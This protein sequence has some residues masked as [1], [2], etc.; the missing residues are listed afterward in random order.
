LEE[1]RTV[2]GHRIDPDRYRSYMVRLWREAS[3]APWRCHVQCVGRDQARCF[4]GLAELFEF[5]EA[6]AAGAE[7]EMW[8]DRETW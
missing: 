8:R 4:A 6:D 1:L 3:G 5:L 2:T 7:W